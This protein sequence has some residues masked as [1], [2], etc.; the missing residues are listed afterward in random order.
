MGCVLAQSVLCVIL[1]WILDIALWKRILLTCV[2][3]FMAMI[4]TVLFAIEYE[5]RKNAKDK[6]KM[7]PFTVNIQHSKFAL[8]LREYRLRNGLD[9]SAAAERLGIKEERLFALEVGNS[10]PTALEKWRLS[11]LIAKQKTASPK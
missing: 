1:A 9:P 2:G 11:R 4:V 6:K 7:T 10:K 5:P 8:M 3:G